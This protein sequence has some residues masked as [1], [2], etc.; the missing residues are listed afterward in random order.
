MIKP[1]TDEVKIHDSLWYQIM[2]LKE[3]YIIITEPDRVP[4]IWNYPLHI[5][6]ILYVN[7]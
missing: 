6:R 7:D 2:G 5:Y 1:L 3:T 4:V